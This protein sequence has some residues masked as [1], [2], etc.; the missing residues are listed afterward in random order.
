MAAGPANAVVST[1][2][3][4]L[5]ALLTSLQKPFTRQVK[6]ELSR[7]SVVRQMRR[8]LIQVVDDRGNKIGARFPRYVLI[9]D[10]ESDRLMF[11]SA[12]RRGR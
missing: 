7:P 1:E 8:Y 12:A 6:A 11:D 10:E 3:R 5:Q 4:S 9:Y 2:D